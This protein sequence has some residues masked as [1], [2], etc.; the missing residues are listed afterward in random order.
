M[1]L[2]WLRSFCEVVM[3]L[4]LLTVMLAGRVWAQSRAQAPAAAPTTAQTAAA[5]T[6]TQTDAAKQ[7]ATMQ[8]KLDD[9]PQLERYRAANAALPAP[10]AGEKRVVFYGDSIT[11]AWAQH[12]DWFFPGKP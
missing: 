6:T 5:P 4:I 9:W 7:I 1:R 2:G 8:K 10:A 11:D 3:R 12:A